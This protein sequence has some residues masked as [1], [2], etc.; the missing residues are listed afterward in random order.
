MYDDI[1]NYVLGKS[2]FQVI[3]TVLV[4]C[5]TKFEQFTTLLTKIPSSSWRN[6]KFA[7]AIA[8]CNII[9][10]SLECLSI[11]ITSGHNQ[12]VVKKVVEAI[13]GYDS[14]LIKSK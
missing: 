12:E 13:E 8:L 7:C 1:P 11:S 6:R 14:D 2:T 10:C 5:R 4:F 3:F 9:Q